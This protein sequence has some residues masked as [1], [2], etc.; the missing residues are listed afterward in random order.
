MEKQEGRREVK[1]KKRDRANGT[2]V[3]F[4]S[5][6][7]KGTRATIVLVP[8]LAKKVGGSVADASRACTNRKNKWSY[9]T[10]KSIGR[11]CV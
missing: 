10:P 6:C 5:K 3:K 1:R 4:L 9:S 7:W 11:V 2:K 8:N